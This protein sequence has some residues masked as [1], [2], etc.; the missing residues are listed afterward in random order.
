MFEQT[1]RYFNLKNLTY[2]KKRKK[3]NEDGYGIVYKERRFLPKI[4][5]MNILQ[6][7]TVMPGERLDNI[8]FRTIGDPEQFWRICD[9]NE[10]MHPLEMTKE[11]GRFLH[12]GTLKIS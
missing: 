5:E 11:S 12:V 6:D 3:N 10:A 4:Q 2:T 7:I 9:A 1:S 8:T